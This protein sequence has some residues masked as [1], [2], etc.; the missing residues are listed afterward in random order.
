MATDLM[1][2]CLGIGTL[3]SC[4]GDFKL[5]RGIFDRLCRLSPGFWCILLGPVEGGR[6]AV[7]VQYRHLEPVLCLWDLSERNRSSVRYTLPSIVHL[8]T[9]RTV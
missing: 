6:H 7:C 2:I 5:S 3:V 4:N 9:F 8:I 1:A